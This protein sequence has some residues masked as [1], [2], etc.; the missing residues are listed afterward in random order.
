MIASIILILH[1]TDLIG[2][3]TV[4]PL[5]YIAGAVLILSDFLVGSMGIIAFNG[6]LSLFIAYTLQT[7]N[8]TLFGYPIDWGMVF[9]IAFF[10]T[11]LLIATFFMIKRV[12]AGKSS[13]GIESMI[14]SEATVQSWD[15]ETGKVSIQGE[16]W[17]AV[18]GK[19][20]DL[21]K[22]DKVNVQSIDKLTLTITG[23]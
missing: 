19:P 9:G 3:E 18:S 15:G 13:V 6:V 11:L 2:M 17:N 20:M 16:T 5:L 1:L 4:L 8:A 10:E 12:N 14:G 22:D 21:E 23:E 7:E